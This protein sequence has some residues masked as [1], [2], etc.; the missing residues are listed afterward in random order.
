MKIQHMILAVI[1]AALWGFNFVVVKLGLSDFPPFLYGAGRFIIAAL[2]IIFFIKNVKL[3]PWHIL[4]GIGFF[5]GFLKFAFMFSG[6]YMGMS[7]GV[8]SL[9]L[10][11]HVF[12][13][14]LLSTLILKTRLTIIQ[15]SGIAVAFCGIVL[16]GIE[17]HAQST[18]LGFTLL[19]GAALSW[20]IAN[21]FYKKAGQVDMIGVT[22]WTSLIPPL[23]MLFASYWFEGD[24]PTVAS[25]GTVSSTG[26][27]CLLYTS[28]ASTL[29]G[30]T[31]WGILLRQYDAPKVAPY[32][33]LT[34]VFGITSA[35]LVLG[36]AISSYT[37]LSCIL[38]FFGLLINQLSPTW[39]IGLFEKLIV[40]K[41]PKTLIARES[42]SSSDLNKAA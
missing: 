18:L 3:P 22:V 36:E 32:S 10:Q 1:V 27:L 34:P 8:A 38:V 12:F 4:A 23:P 5:M 16:M 40:W 39:L 42:S 15:V 26:W 41:T 33:L 35:W 17:M 7:A 9:I 29:I 21:I 31:L 13:T 24:L 20:S 11:S 19:V 28:C 14:V 30:A 2:P 6:I 37:M 25:L